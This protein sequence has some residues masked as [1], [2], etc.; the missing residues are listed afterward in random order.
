MVPVAEASMARP[1]VLALAE[2]TAVTSYPIVI[3]A[4]VYKGNP[5]AAVATSKP[6]GRAA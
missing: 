5:P 6:Q 2:A 1:E 4:E 3:T